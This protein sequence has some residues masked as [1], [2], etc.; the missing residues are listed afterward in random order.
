M[1]YGKTKNT[2]SDIDSILSINRWIN[3][4]IK[5]DIGA[6]FTILCQLYTEQL[7][8]VVISYIVYI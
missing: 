8:I 1:L 7:D 6:V 3:R 4:I 2:N 5:L